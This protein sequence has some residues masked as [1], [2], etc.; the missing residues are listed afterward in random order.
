LTEYGSL[1]LIA[2]RPPW[3]PNL[4][5]WS[6]VRVAQLRSSAD[7]HHWS[8]YWADRNCRWHRYDDL[9]PGSV[10]EAL[11]EIEADPTCSFW[12]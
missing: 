2:R 12:G 4:T 10:D 3:N 1:K 8:L 5:E 9:D 6:K 11:N 7:T